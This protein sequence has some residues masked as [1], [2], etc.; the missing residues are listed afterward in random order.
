VLSGYL[1]KFEKKPGS[2]RAIARQKENTGGAFWDKLV[3]LELFTNP[4]R[5]D[6]LIET[7][8]N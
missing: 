8:Y 6:E 4:R 7:D 2:S 1:H 5:S 3:V